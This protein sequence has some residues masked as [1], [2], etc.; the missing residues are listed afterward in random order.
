M[1][2]SNKN[3]TSNTSKND[4]CEMNDMLQNMSTADSDNSNDISNTCAN[5]GEE[6]S[7]VTNT[8]NKCN[9]V[10]YCNAVCKKKHRSKHKKQCERR[11]AELHDEKLFKQPPPGE[12]CPICFLQMP[13]LISGSVY[14][15]CC[16]KIIC[17]GCIHAVQMRDKGV[18]LCPFCRI[19]RPTSDE[20]ATKRERKRM[21]VGDADAIYSIGCDYSRGDNGYTRDRAKALELWHKAADLGHAG[22]HYNIACA[23]NNGTGVEMDKQKAE[24]YCELAAMKGH[25]EARHKLGYIEVR[26]GNI[27][28]AMKHFMLGVESGWAD[29]LS[30]IKNFHSNGHAT[31][32][33]YTTALRL[34][35][36]YL[37]EVK[38]A[39][40]DEAAGFG[41]SFKYID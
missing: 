18:G 7:D 26:K 37:N 17:C 38:S 8:C 5:C 22:A 30:S 40:R 20:E 35:Q 31:K 25:A 2:S 29:S 11:V 32:E 9:S 12:D 24:H 14:K 1:S 33:S 3:D 21:D 36:E 6:G 10:M 15:S 16:G 4:V 41:E 28:R 27:D 13:A 39:Q 19:P 23:Y 34:Y